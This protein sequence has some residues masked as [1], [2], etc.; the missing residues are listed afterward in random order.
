MDEEDTYIPAVNAIISTG[1]DRTKQDTINE[2]FEELKTRDAITETFEEFMKEKGNSKIQHFEFHPSVLIYNAVLKNRFEKNFT[3]SALDWYE[4]ISGTGF[5]ECFEASFVPSRCVEETTT[6]VLTNIYTSLMMNSRQKIR[7]NI[8]YI[9]Y[10][11]TIKLAKDFLKN[12]GFRK[13][14]KNITRS[15]NEALKHENGGIHVSKALK[16]I[17]QQKDKR[18]DGTREKFVDVLG[19]MKSEGHEVPTNDTKNLLKEWYLQETKSKKGGKK[20]YRPYDRQFKTESLDSK[21]LKLYQEFGGEKKDL[22]VKTPAQI[23]EEKKAAAERQRQEREANIQREIGWG[24]AQRE[25]PQTEYKRFQEEPGE[26]IEFTIT[27]VNVRENKFT[28]I[29]H[30][31]NG[32]RHQVV[33]DISK[34]DFVDEPTR[35]DLIGQQF[36]GIVTGHKGNHLNI[37]D[38]KPYEKSP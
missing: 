2:I 7:E 5:S 25:E 38:I 9:E 8:E 26:E 28:L 24:R 3:N 31:E 18:T 27:N 1:F 29:G 32:Y 34:S 14:S 11:N 22:V 4:N 35:D 19:F 30:A 17:K 23:R 16:I 15:V 12:A 33:G 20:T 37:I 36:V 21:I 10:I 6:D 13:E